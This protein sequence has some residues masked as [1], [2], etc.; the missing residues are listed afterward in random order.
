MLRATLFSGFLLLISTALFGQNDTINQR[1]EN[2]RKQGHWIYYGKDRPTSG[3]PTDGK[4][5]EGNYVDDRKHGNWYK[6][7]LDGKTLKLKGNYVNNRPYGDFWKYYSDGGLREYGTYK[8]NRYVG[9]N[10]RY[11]ENRNIESYVKYDDRGQMIDTAKYFFIGGC[12]KGTIYYS[13]PNIAEY[14]VYYYKDS[15]NVVK[16]SIYGSRVKPEPEPHPGIR[17]INPNEPKKE[18]PKMQGT[19]RY[20]ENYAAEMSDSTICNAMDYKGKCYNVNHEILFSG[21]CQ[22]GKILEGHLYF[23]DEDGILLKV[24]IWENGKYLKDGVL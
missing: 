18:N 16:D 11:Y 17:I 14:S 23:Y 24:E 20:H 8:K 5:E 10:V 4:I 7:H 13:S 3:Y 9:L 12:K 1:D 19:W 6:Y 21:T 22:D 15:C 2:G